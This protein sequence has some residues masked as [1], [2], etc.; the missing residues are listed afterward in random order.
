MDHVERVFF[1]TFEV[2]H[3]FNGTKPHYHRTI[4]ME[5]VHT[6]HRVRIKIYS[7]DVLVVNVLL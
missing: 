2:D 6:G 3:H 1:D 7:L 4:T 5:T